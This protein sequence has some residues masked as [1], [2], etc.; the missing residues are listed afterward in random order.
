MQC[1]DEHCS[2]AKNKF[3]TVI[4]IVESQLLVHPKGVGVMDSRSSVGVY[5]KSA[6]HGTVKIP[7]LQKN[8]KTKKQNT[9]NKNHNTQHAGASQL[10]DQNISS[11]IITAINGTPELITAINNALQNY[12]LQ[13]LST[14]DKIKALQETYSTSIIGT[15][16]FDLIYTGQ[17]LTHY[18][19]AKN[20]SLIWN[21]GV[22]NSKSITAGKLGTHIYVYKDSNTNLFKLLGVIIR[23]DKMGLFDKISNGLTFMGF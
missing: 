13:K 7:N 2:E 12:D 5:D 19:S 18:D 11:Q 4:N 22:N 21:H 17:K 8:K 16:L 20:P 3:N 23:K 14:K 15:Q 9:N 10:T 6:P 1:I